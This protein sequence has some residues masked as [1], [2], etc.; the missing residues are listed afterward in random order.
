MRTVTFDI[1]VSY[2][3]FNLYKDRKWVEKV[4][5]VRIRSR[6]EIVT[7]STVQRILSYSGE[8]IVMDISMVPLLF[9]KN[10]IKIDAYVFYTKQDF[11]VG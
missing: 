3:F 4:I 5:L 1:S 9:K 7:L 8:Q 10:K 6:K 2:L 11:M